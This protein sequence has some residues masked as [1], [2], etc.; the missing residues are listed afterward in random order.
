MWLANVLKG[1]RLRNKGRWKMLGGINLNE[2]QNV[3]PNFVCAIVLYSL[4]V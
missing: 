1:V 2:S 3:Y 4:R